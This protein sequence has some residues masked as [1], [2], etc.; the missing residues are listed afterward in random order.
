M[1]RWMFKTRL[2]TLGRVPDGFSGYPTHWVGPSR[3]GYPRLPRLPPIFRYLV[4]G[5]LW[6]GY[7]WAGRNSV[8]GTHGYP[9]RSLFKTQ[10]CSKGMH[11]EIRSAEL[12]QCGFILKS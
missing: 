2:R 9:V 11:S 10:K 12:C 3:D 8:T 5:T 6:V 1:L 7:P 4:M